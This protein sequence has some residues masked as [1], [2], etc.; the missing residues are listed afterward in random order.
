VGVGGAGGNPTV[1]RKWAVRAGEGWPWAVGKSDPLGFERIGDDPAAGNK[2]EQLVKG[3]AGVALTSRDKASLMISLSG[4]RKPWQG[5]S[6]SEGVPW[7]L[8]TSTVAVGVRSGRSRAAT[9]AMVP[10]L[11]ATTTGR[12]AGPR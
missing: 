6:L 1:S 5:T 4:Y 2:V 8:R 3:L 7:H 11:L 9:G 10:D 12:M